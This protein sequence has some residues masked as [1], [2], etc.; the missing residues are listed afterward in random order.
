MRRCTNALPNGGV[1]PFRIRQPDKITQACPRKRE[2]GTFLLYQSILSNALLP[3][4]GH[5]LLF[6][7]PQGTLAG[8]PVF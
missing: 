2:H 4:F 1:L 5:P 7:A 6:M 3:A 8:K